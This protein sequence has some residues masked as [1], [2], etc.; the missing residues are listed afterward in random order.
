[1]YFFFNWIKISGVQGH[2]ESHVSYGD[3]SCCLHTWHV[4][5]GSHNDNK[6]GKRTKEKRVGPT[7]FVVGQPFLVGPT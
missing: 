6:T 1:M 7:T 2:N 4:S 3:V 5:E